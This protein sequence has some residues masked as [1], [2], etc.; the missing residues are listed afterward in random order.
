MSKQSSFKVHSAFKP[1]LAAHKKLLEAAADAGMTAVVDQAAEDARSMKRWRDP[2]ESNFGEWEWTT[3]GLSVES[4]SGHVVT[5][6]KSASGYKRLRRAP[7]QVLLRGYPM[8]TTEHSTTSR[9]KRRSTAGKVLGV[10]TMYAD[11][12]HWVQRMEIEGS[13]G[14]S[15]SPGIPVVIEV[16][17]SNWANYYVPQI[18][19]PTLQAALG[20]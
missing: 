17:Q 18:L 16:F 1:K 13:L 11:Y 2:G 20:V 7:T 8:H 6:R 15:I 5:P 10:V 3:T 9:P 12:A 19:R 4:I 14:G